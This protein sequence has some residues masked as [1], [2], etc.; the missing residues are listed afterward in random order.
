VLGAFL[1][2]VRACLRRSRRQLVGYAWALY[3]SITAPEDHA[4]QVETI[5]PCRAVAPEARALSTRALPRLHGRGRR[6]V[7]RCPLLD[8]H[9]DTRAA[10]GQ[11]AP[12]R[13]RA[14]RVPHR[15]LLRP[16]L[17][18]GN[19]PAAAHQGD[20]ALDDKHHFTLVCADSAKFR[21]YVQVSNAMARSRPRR[22]RYTFI[23]PR[24]A[25]CAACCTRN[26]HTV[27]VCIPAHGHAGDHRR[28]GEPLCRARCSCPV[29]PSR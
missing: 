2:R 14:D 7:V 3:T 17:H 26:K 23:L 10:L 25:R 27:G 9:P 15:L 29:T 11:I 12:A 16:G 1:T 19:A 5:C 21:H 22:R 6:T 18:R 28:A 20:P 4:R 8:V 13:R 24:P